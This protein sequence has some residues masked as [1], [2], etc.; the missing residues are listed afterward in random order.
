MSK[1]KI[2]REAMKRGMVSAPGAYDCITARATI[3]GWA[4]TSS[5]VQILADGAP[6]AFSSFSQALASC[7]ARA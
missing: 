5:I 4:M 6:A 2:F 7:F 1:G 3:W